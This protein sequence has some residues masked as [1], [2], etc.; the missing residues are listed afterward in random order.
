MKNF[1][2][3]FILTVSFLDL[4]AQNSNS[5]TEVNEKSFPTNIN[6]DNFNKLEEFKGQI[7][8]FDGLIEKKENSRNN[9]PFYKLKIGP[10]KYIWTVL[11]FD[12]KVN[13]VGDNVRVVGY[14][15]LSEPDEN[16][17]KFLD[18]EYMIIA[19]GLVD[20]KNSNFLFLGGANK[21]KQDWINGM[22]PRV[23]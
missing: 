3:L 10:R 5:K 15:N 11:M 13:K 19:L 1:L 16:E 8:A 23:K 18:T 12:N 22:I 6:Q 2:I 17:K 20:F 4:P 14:L 9:T 7:I 21:Q